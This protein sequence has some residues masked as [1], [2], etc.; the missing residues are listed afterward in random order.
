[1][2]RFWNSVLQDVSGGTILSFFVASVTPAN[3]SD[4]QATD[5]SIDT[6]PAISVI[7]SCQY[8]LCFFSKLAPIRAN[9][10]VCLLFFRRALIVQQ[11]F[12]CAAIKVFINIYISLEHGVNWKTSDEALHP[13]WLVALR[14]I[15]GSLYDDSGGRCFLL[16]LAAVLLLISMN[17][18]LADCRGSSFLGLIKSQFVLLNPSRHFCFSCSER[19]AVIGIIEDIVLNWYIFVVLLIIWLENWRARYRQWWFW[20]SVVVLIVVVLIVVVFW[21]CVCFVFDVEE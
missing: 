4:P 2:F 11:S 1:M 19:P 6:I 10:C 5:P 7:W 20:R 14:S 15:R 3:W 13:F 16:L 17:S 8:S 18:K 12:A 21:L 9:R